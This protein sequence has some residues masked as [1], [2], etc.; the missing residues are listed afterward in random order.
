MSTEHGVRHWALQQ[1]HDPSHSKAVGVV[2]QY[3]ARRS[4]RASILPAWPPDSSDLNLIENLWGWLAPK[5]DSPGGKSFDAYSAAV[6]KRLTMLPRT[7]LRSLVDSVPR[8]M[9]E[10]LRLGGGKIKY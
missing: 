6:L 4:T 10:G 2:E 1:A 3:N 8:G 9:A 5:V 7:L